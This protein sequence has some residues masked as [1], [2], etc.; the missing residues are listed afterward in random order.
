[1]H[2]LPFLTLMHTHNFS[3]CLFTLLQR[4]ECEKQVQRAAVYTETGLGLGGAG[5]KQLLSSVCYSGQRDIEHAFTQLG[6]TAQRD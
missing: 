3:P 6:Q 2:H 5:V 1:M 4:C